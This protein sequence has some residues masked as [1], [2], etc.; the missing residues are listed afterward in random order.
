NRDMLVL[1]VSDDANT[2][3]QRLLALRKSDKTWRRVAMPGEQLSWARGFGKFIALAESGTKGTQTPESA[4]RAEWRKGE[5]KM[6]PSIHA[7]FNDGKYVFHGRLHLY[8]LD[9]GHT[10]TITTNQGD[11]EILLVD[12]STVYY[13]AS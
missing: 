6:G 8:D 9:N 10:Y 4:G 5:S 11:S 7:R 13:R 12:N 3:N 2:H 1:G